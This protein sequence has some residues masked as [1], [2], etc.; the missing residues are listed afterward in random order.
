MAKVRM[1]VVRVSR[2]S[3]NE[4]IFN[5]RNMFH[6]VYMIASKEGYSALF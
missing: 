5:Y 4:V 2:A 1:Q 3:K 6:G